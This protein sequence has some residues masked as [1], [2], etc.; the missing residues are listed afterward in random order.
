MTPQTQCFQFAKEMGNLSIMFCEARLD[1]NAQKFWLI[2]KKLKR[3]IDQNDNGSANNDDERITNNIINDLIS[4]VRK[5]KKQER[6]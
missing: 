4:N 5:Q 6:Q 3:M 2:I 1:H